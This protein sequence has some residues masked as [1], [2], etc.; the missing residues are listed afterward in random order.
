MLGVVALGM[1]GTLGQLTLGIVGVAVPGQE[2]GS[3]HFVDMLVGSGIEYVN[4]SGDS[5]KLLILGSL[6]SGVLLLDYDND[7][8]LDLYFLNGALLKGGQVEYVE[9]NR[10]Y[11][12]DNYWN[13]TDVTDKAGIG[14]AGWGMGGAVGD[15]DNDGH[16][17]IF[18]TNIGP[19]VLYRNQGD[20]TFADITGTS[21]IE[22]ESW[23][24]SAA[25]LDHDGDGD[26]DL[27]V[28]NY[29]DPSL[30]RI[31]R[32]GGRVLHAPGTEGDVECRYRSVR[33]FCGP[34]GLLGARDIFYVNQGNGTF[35]DATRRAGVFDAKLSYGLGV[36]VGDYDDDGDAD[37]FVANDSMANLLYQNRA[38]SSFEEVA[39]WAGVALNQDAVAEAGMG[40][41]MGDA[42]ADGWL[43]F[44]V[45]NFSEESNTLYR[46]L[47]NRVFVDSSGQ[48]GLGPPSLPYLGWATR[49]FDVD[50]DGDEDLFVANGHVYPQVE[51]LDTGFRY[52][53]ANRLFL[54]GGK[55]RFQDRRATQSAEGDAFST[56][57]GGFG[58]IDNDGYV[59]AILVNIDAPPSLLRNRRVGEDHWVSFQLVGVRSNRS[60]IGARLTLAARS[61]SQIK[62]VRPS[63]SYLSS[64]DLRV[65][66]G[67]GSSES[68]DSLVIRWPRGQVHELTGLPADRHYVVTEDGR[69]W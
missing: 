66:F 20:G 13:F 53:Q 9:K 5:E 59:D 27:Y 6:G 2:P 28:V 24:T 49:F 56:R 54:N 11:R 4:V 65:H 58:D 29:L 44:F 36:V 68:V 22:D 1:L 51:L 40:V 21:H 19:N 8:D 16:S 69:M 50:N 43:D 57:G 25:F 64:N 7:G 37:I 31:P 34:E 33:V 14:D 3:P 46:N 35:S 17:D 41:D 12:N 48:S 42:D 30:K 45:T 38:D 67:L 15:F 63:G 47:G 32:A 18:V 52:A 60:A 61:G 55:G 10:L 62:E 39:L 26:L 23:G